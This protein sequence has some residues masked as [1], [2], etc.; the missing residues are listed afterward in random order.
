MVDSSSTGS[1]YL[2]GPIFSGTFEIEL[3]I[4]EANGLMKRTWWKRDRR[5]SKLNYRGLE[6]LDDERVLYCIADP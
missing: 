4:D 1:N 2:H 5:L 3:W 6:K